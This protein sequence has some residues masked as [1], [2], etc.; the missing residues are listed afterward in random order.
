MTHNP[1]SENKTHYS[2]ILN[3]IKVLSVHYAPLDFGCIGLP[4]TMQR[5]RVGFDGSGKN[6][7]VQE[8]SVF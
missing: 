7:K 4:I 8:L 2:G 1:N 3:Q 5:Q 6:A